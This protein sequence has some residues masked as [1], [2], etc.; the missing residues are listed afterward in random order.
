MRGIALTGIVDEKVSLGQAN[1]PDVE[2]IVRG[3]E[4]YA[5]Y[6]T[7]D[8]Y[9]VVYDDAR[10]VFCFAQVIDGRF[11]STGVSTA[12]PP[13]AG[14]KHHAVESDVVRTEKIQARIREMNQMSKKNNDGRIE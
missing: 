11:E 14:V 12:S 7:P 4:L 8:G 2:L 3:T 13:P 1:G 5:N 6:E 10:G 9:P